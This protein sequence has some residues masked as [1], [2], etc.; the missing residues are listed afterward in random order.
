[1]KIKFEIDLTVLGQRV[2]DLSRRFKISHFL[3]LYFAAHMLQIAFP[4]DGSMVF[5]EAYYVP[6]SL[7]TLAG[8]AANLEHPPLGKL[9]GAAGIA[10][11]GNNWFGWRFPQVVISTVGLYL[12]YLVAKRL[13]G[14]DPW[15]LGATIMLGLDT[16]FFIHGGILLLDAPAFML[17]FLTLEL[18]FRKRYWW[19]AIC[20]GLAFFDRE[21]TVF[22]FVTLVAYHIAVNRGAFK[23]AAKFLSRYTLAALLVLFILLWAYDI[24]F[25]PAQSTMVTSNINTNVVVGQSGQPITTIIQTFMSTSSENIMRNPVQNIMFDFN[26]NGPHGIVLNETTVHAYEHPVDWILP[27]DPFDQPTYYRVDITVTAGNVTNDYTPIWYQAQPNLPLW[28]GIWPAAF[29]LALALIRRKEWETALFIAVGIGSNYLPW[30]V[31]DML[32]RRIGFNY[33]YLYTLPFVALGLVFAI[34]MLPRNTAKIILASY[35]IVELAFFLWFF[36]VHPIGTG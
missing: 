16:I 2:L 26:Y 19:S 7:T 21:L 29:G 5:D 33:Y 6:A 18:Y 35:I 8:E 17:G 14:G 27:I 30:V 13:L 25:Q 24:H 4:S 23:Q 15:A 9:I 10:L 36:P 12:F 22:I 3:L 32:V 20:M 1:L 34:K 31:L 28:Y 11:F